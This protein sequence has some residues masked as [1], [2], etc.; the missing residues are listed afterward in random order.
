MEPV[1][2]LARCIVYNTAWKGV[3]VEKIGV[4]YLLCSGAYLGTTSVMTEFI[5]HSPLL[6]VCI[7]EA[8]HGA[9]LT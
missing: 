4:Y 3:N 9:N 1:F 7:V 8:P 5:T 2:F 6:G